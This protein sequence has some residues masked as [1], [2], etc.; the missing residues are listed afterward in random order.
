MKIRSLL[1]LI[2]LAIA[3][4]LP[5]F[6]QQTTLPDPQLRD[7]FVAGNKKL[8]DA[9]LKSDAAT[10]AGFYTEDA[11]LVEPNAGPIYGK[12]AIEKFFADGFQK[13]HF[14]KHASN[15][16]TYSPHIIG[17]AGNEVWVTGEWSAT[18]QV[19]NGAP[20]QAHGRFLTICVHEGDAWKS[21]VDTYYAVAPPTPA[22]TK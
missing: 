18:F 19:E 20:M 2:G 12:E 9:M 3:F 15:L 6:A 1:T 21:Q 13:M 7:V 14:T 10:M 4:A 11:C 17:T 16:E 5:T 22:E 8:D